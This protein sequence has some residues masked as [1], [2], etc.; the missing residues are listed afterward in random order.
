MW[1]E[2]GGQPHFRL[3][4]TPVTVHGSF[5]FLALYLGYGAFQTDGVSGLLLMVLAVTLSILVHEFGHVFAAHTNGFRSRVILLGF[6][7]VTIPEGKAHG[8][9]SIWMSAAGPMFGLIFWMFIWFGYFWISD[10]DLGSP[11][12][13][14]R[15]L[16]PWSVY[17]RVNLSV[18]AGPYLWLWVQLC[19]INLFLSLLNLAPVFPLDGGHILDEALRMKLRAREAQRISA[20]VGV[21]V[22][23][24]AAVWLFTAFGG[25]LSLLIFGMLAWQNWERWQEVR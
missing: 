25:V 18:G 10:H 3:F 4:G 15:W 12:D 13:A 9:R 19:W 22:A 24:L 16:Q 21:V 8:W 17:D 2:Q 5:L 7:G 23:S 11:F 20:L 14:S 1:N 6:G